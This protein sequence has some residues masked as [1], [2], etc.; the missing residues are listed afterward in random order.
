MCKCAKKIEHKLLFGFSATD[1]ALAY[2]RT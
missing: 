2:K 1:P